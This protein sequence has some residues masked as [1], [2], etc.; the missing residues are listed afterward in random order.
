MGHPSTSTQ[1]LKA[2][3]NA[4]PAIFS[5]QSA[6]DTSHQGTYNG[7]PDQQK[8]LHHPRYPAYSPSAHYSQPRAYSPCSYQSKP[9]HAPFHLRKSFNSLRRYTGILTILS[10]S[11]SAV[12]SVGMEV[13]MVYMTYTFY[14][15]KGHDP[16]YDQRSGPWA[17]HTKLWPTYLLLGASGITCLLSLGILVATCCKSRKKALFSVFYHIVH[18][19]LW[20]GVTVL[21]RV[22]KTGDDL[23]GWS[24]SEN[25]DNIQDLFKGVVNFN[26]LCKLQVLMAFPYEKAVH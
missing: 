12:L 21:Y 18:V 4:L 16:S 25:A 14:H 8:P 1:P 22:G 6:Q 7:L 26:G 11:I 15:T 17:K 2:L 3:F 9:G 5:G 10:T 19:L 23:W 13:I 24:C 20:A